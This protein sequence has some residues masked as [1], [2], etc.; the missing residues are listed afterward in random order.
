[1]REQTTYEAGEDVY[2][3]SADFVNGVVHEGVVGLRDSDAQGQS[4]QV[5]F[6]HDPY[7]GEA[8][9]RS[10]AV[11]PEQMIHRQ[12]ETIEFLQFIGREDLIEPEDFEDE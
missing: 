8:D 1:M 4:I 5:A 3:I 9:H 10:I 7:G 6:D 11:M 12:A 2:V